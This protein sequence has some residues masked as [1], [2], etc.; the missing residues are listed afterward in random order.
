MRAA[1]AVAREFGRGAVYGIEWG[2]P[3]VRDPLRFVRDRYVL[4]FVKPDQI[5]VEIGPGGGRWTRYLLGFKTLYA[6]E[7]YDALIAEF[8]KT[9]GR[10][11]RVKVIKNNCEIQK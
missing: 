3:D 7:Y 8:E 1:R 9:Y 10:D 5:A 6:V 2:D 11:D 4:P